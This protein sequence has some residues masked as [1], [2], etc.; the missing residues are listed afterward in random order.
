[1]FNIGE[2]VKIKH[3]NKI[4]VILSREKISGKYVVFTQDEITPISLFA[5]QIENVTF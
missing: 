4:D 5:E 3:N 2:M 1:M